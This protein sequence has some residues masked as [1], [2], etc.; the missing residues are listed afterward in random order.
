MIS[1]MKV[2][3]LMQPAKWNAIEATCHMIFDEWRV[4]FLLQ[5][6]V[7]YPSAEKTIVGL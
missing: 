1:P 5:G 7:G 2:Y 3:N 6:G 4:P